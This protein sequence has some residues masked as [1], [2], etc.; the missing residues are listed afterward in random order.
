MFVNG[1]EAQ[2][3]MFN[4][5]FEAVGGGHR[6]GYDTK[7]LISSR[8]IFLLKKINLSV[9]IPKRCERTFGALVL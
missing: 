9:I 8:L 6:T 2:Q 4:G 5:M 1:D 7:S 3:L